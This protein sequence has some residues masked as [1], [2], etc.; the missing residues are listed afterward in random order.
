MPNNWML[1]QNMFL[2]KSSLMLL[3]VW[4]HTFRFLVV[5]SE[6]QVQETKW[7]ITQCMVQSVT[8][9]SLLPSFTIKKCQ[10]KYNMWWGTHTCW[11]KGQLSF[12][13]LPC[14]FVSASKLLKVSILS[15]AFGVSPLNVEIEPTTSLETLTNFPISKS[16]T[17]S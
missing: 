5:L 7:Q 14:N 6:L 16:I 11:F 8:R 17:S 9:S 12:Q 3:V 2:H 1:S 13:Y 4:N 10:R 15:K